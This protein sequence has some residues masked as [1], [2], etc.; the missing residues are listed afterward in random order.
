MSAGDRLPNRRA[1]ETVEF[2]HNGFRFALSF[3][4]FATGASPFLSSRKPGSPIE[5]IAA[6]PP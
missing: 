3:G 2:T 5:A 4:R 6:T 1:C